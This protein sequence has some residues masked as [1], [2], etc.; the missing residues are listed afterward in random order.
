M[1]EVLINGPQCRYGEAERDAR[2]VSQLTIFI[3]I[4]YTNNRVFW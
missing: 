4:T 2:K 1:A 3:F